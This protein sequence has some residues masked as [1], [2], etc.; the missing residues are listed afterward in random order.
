MTTTALSKDEILEAIGKMS[1]LDLA[2]LIEAFKSKFNVTVMRGCGRA[3]GRVGRPPRPRSRRSSP[4]S[5]RAAARRR[6]RSSR[7]CASS[8]AWA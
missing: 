7:W 5:S 8:P 3:G 4:S 6:S 1:V 2:D